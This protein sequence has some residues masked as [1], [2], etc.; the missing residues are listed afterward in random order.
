MPEYCGTGVSPAQSLRGRTS[1]P[2]ASL[3]PAP[4]CSSPGGTTSLPRRPQTH[5]SPRI[6]VPPKFGLTLRAWPLR[7]RPAAALQPASRLPRSQQ[8]AFLLHGFLPQLWLGAGRSPLP[9]TKP[10]ILQTLLRSPRVPERPS[11][12]HRR[13]LATEVQT[14]HWAPGGSPAQRQPRLEAGDPETQPEP[15]G[16]SDGTSHPRHEAPHRKSKGESR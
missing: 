15:T 8:A 13:A 10:S 12:A 7:L 14:A 5:A 16:P 2:S 6:I 9:G 3:P 11:L 1:S 4:S